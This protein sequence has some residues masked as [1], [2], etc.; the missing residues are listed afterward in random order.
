MVP[1]KNFTVPVGFPIGLLVPP[2]FAGV[3]VAVKLT[4]VPTFCGEFGDAATVVVV[5]SPMV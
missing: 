2:M 5:G 3:I 1:S 4:L